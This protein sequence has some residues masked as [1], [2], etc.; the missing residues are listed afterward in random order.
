VFACVALAAALGL[1]PSLARAEATVLVEVRPPAE[2]TV[3]ITPNAP[4]SRSYSCTVT[5]GQC[6]IAGVPG[7]M[8]TVRFQPTTGAAPPPHSVMIAPTGNVRLT[9]P[10]GR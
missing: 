1:D 3:T 2:G 10:S 5:A 8:A 9:V 7:G 4:G 6:T